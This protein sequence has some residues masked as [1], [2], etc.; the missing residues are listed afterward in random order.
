MLEGRVLGAEKSNGGGGV[1]TLQA[2]PCSQRNVWG[3]DSPRTVGW[4]RRPQLSKPR[5]QEGPRP[6][7]GL[8]LNTA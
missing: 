5:R 6:L 7:G 1:G 3:L 2:P 4:A 8:L